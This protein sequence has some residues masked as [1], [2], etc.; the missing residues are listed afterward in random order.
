MTRRVL[1]ILAAVALGA[2]GTG[3][4][5][6]FASAPQV[7]MLSGRDDH[8]LLERPAIGLQRS[9]ADRTVTATAHDGEFVE[10]LRRDGLHA[11]VRLAK[12]G[13]EG[14]IADHDLRGEA[15]RTEP[16]PRRVT[17]VAVERRE[18]KVHVHVRY[19]DDGSDG[20]VPASALRE[21]GAR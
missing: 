16:R 11:Y 3:G 19:A 1:A 15:V 2:L 9:P 10:V 8:G 17:F 6:L 21:V 14:W 5:G 13:E 20:W 18:G 4:C 7:A 12:S